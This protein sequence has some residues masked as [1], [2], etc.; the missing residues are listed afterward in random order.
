MYEYEWLIL[1]SIARKIHFFSIEGLPQ[2]KVLR[3][4]VDDII[5]VDLYKSHIV[6][7]LLRELYSLLQGIEDSL[8]GTGQSFDGFLSF[9]AVAFKVENITKCGMDLRLR[10]SKLLIVLQV[11]HLPTVGSHRFKFEIKSLLPYNH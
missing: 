7:A 8:I 3:V 5:V 9:G 2:G 10:A 4:L 1:V 11:A 6:I